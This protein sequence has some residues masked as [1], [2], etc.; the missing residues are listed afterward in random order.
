MAD[1]LLERLV[2]ERD[3]RLALIRSISDSAAEAE[4]DLSDQDRETIT[5]ARTRLAAIDQQLELIGDNLDMNDEVR[6]RLAR[7]QPG[8]VT[9]GN[10]VYRTAGDLMWDMLHA[11]SDREAAHRYNKFVT[12]AAEHMGTTA[13]ATTPTAGGFAGLLVVPTVGPVLD[14]KPSGRPLITAL[15]TQPMPNAWSFTRPRIVDAHLDDGVGVQ[16]LQ[17]AEL[18]SKHFDILGDNVAPITVG[19]YLNVSQQLLS[20]VAQGLDLIVNQMSKRL[21]RYE[22]RQPSRRWPPRRPR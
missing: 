11:H 4:R 14:L 18:V 10:V 12:R 8:V 22:G 6:N 1:A 13:S 21:A 15:G 16:A 2:N 20:F 17:K 5:A 19:G 7:L 9:P 3:Q